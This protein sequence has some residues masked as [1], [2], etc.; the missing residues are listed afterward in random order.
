MDLLRPPF[1]SMLVVVGLIQFLNTNASAL[2]LIWGPLFVH[3][4]GL[5]TQL[6]SVFFSL[7]LST[8]VVFGA[9]FNAALVDRV[10][11]RPLLL[12]AAAFQAVGFLLLAVTQGPAP[13][14]ILIVFPVLSAANLVAAVS[15]YTWT[16]EFFPTH[17]RARANSLLF[18]SPRFGAV[19]IG[20]LTPLLMALGRTEAVLLVGTAVEAA[21]LVIGLLWWRVET[22]G[23]SLEEIPA[24]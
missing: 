7:V 12:G 15:A 6:G 4:L 21:V 11:R 9:A 1:L 10:G 17:V 20:I 14:L 18:A 19:P 24:P 13:H 5:T 22:R 23:R 16:P 3:N 2:L 8:G